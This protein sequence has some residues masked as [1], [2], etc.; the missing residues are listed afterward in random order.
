M[1]ME[2]KQILNSLMSWRTRLVGVSYSVLKDSHLAEDIFQDLLLKALRG[3]SKFENEKALIS[4]S[5]VTVRRAS[6]DQ[7][8]KKK[9]EVMVLDDEVLDL[10]E[11]QVLRSTSVSESQQRDALE[12][13]LNNLTKRSQ[14]V[15]KLRY[16]YGHNCQEVAS[17]VNMSL[18]AVYKLLSRV[19]LKLRN[20]IELKINRTPIQ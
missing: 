3:D 10:L 20:C 11:K 15:L 17:R 2:E 19:H 4:W 1:E 8:R 6:I 16:Y 18:D 5:V 7:L 14:S 9:R 12:S 13:C